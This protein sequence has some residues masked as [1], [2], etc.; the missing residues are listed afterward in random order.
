[1]FGN[2][3]ATGLPN[4]NAV[5]LD[6]GCGIS[7]DL[8][9]Y[10]DE[11]G[12]TNYTGLEPLDVDVR[13]TYR[14]LTA[15]AESIPFESAS[16]DAVLFATSLDHIADE[17]AAIAEVKRVLKPGGRIFFW[18]GLYEP[19]MLARAKTFEQ[20]LAYNPIVGV[21]FILAEALLTVKRMWKRKRQLKT[22]A[23]IDSAHERWYTRDRLRAS[24]KRWELT[25]VRE[26]EP[27]GTASIFVEAKH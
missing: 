11:L 8:P 20:S 2:F 7:P 21:P 6:I 23:R 17:D 5:V 25:A 13:R 27:P 22:G 1:M 9:L 24:L 3:I 4:R 10:V 14:C 15:T 26:L 19:I 16:V 18:Q 12:L